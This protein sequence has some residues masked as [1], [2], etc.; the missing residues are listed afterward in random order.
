MDYGWKPGQSGNPNGRPSGARNKSSYQLRERLKERG[1]K[2]PAEFLSE[3]VSNE[4]DPKELRIAASREL[5]PYFYSK[6]GATPVPIPPQYVQEAVSLP[7]PKNIDE[8]GPL[9]SRNCCV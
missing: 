1:D 3:I 9:A 5:M 8:I 6:L 2:D 7:R 4:E